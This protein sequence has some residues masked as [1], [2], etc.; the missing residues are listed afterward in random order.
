VCDKRGY[1]TSHSADG[2]TTSQMVHNGSVAFHYAIHSQIASVACVGDL[3]VLKRLDSSLNSVKGRAAIFQ[4]E[5][6]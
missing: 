6:G 3:S 1:T 2:S 4:D 5:H